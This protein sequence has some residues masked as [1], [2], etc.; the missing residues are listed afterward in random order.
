MRRR[1]AIY[2]AAPVGRASCQSKVA[3]A[4]PMGLAGL[5]V[6]RQTCRLERAA[7]QRRQAASTAGAG[8]SER[9]PLARIERHSRPGRQEPRALPKSTSGRSRGSQGK[10]PGPRVAWPSARLVLSS[11]GRDGL[12]DAGSP[13]AGSALGGA[14]SALPAPGGSRRIR[15]H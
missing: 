8:A 13:D 1:G 3:L 14:Q 5:F 7:A 6:D 12:S 11:G 15:L 9:A 10:R 2:W 4:P